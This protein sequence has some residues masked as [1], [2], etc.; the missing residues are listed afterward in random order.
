[1]TQAVNK[2]G[3]PILRLQQPDGSW[4]HFHTLSQP[5]KARPMTTE[6]ALRRLSVLGLTYKDEP[7]QRAVG[8][9]KDVLDGRVVPPD[10]RE[11]ALNWNFFE[12]MMMAT[13]I[14]RFLPHDEQAL[15]IAAFW[16]SL[17]QKS[18]RGGV[19]DAGAYEAE[20][21]RH[22]PKLHK[23]EHIIGI[24]QFYMVS[25]L[26]DML[27]EETEK[28]FVAYAIDNPSGIY[29]VYSE[30]IAQVPTAFQ[31]LQTSRYLGAL[32]CLSGYGRASGRLQFAADWLALQK[33]G[34]GWDLG[35]AARDGVYFPISDS[36]QKPENRRK[37]CTERIEK[38]L[39]AIGGEPSC[40]QKREPSG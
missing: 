30:R 27:D 12:K 20:Y 4:G 19:V 3:D 15:E 1:M 31:S 38:L 37:D 2:W 33:D 36:W 32:E 28:A 26:W 18:I 8:Y 29:Y 24:S 34:D 17:L 22:I 25:L 16:A 6:Q 9:M 23:Q 13:W 21:R 5:T 10:G 40:H 11:Q 35:A 14:K 7:I 39:E